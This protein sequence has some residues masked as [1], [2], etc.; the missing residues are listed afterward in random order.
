MFTKRAFANKRSVDNGGGSKKY[1]LP[2]TVGVPAMLHRFINIRAGNKRGE[3]NK[4]W[5]FINDLKSPDGDSGDP[6]YFGASVAIYG[7]Y[8]VVGATYQDVSDNDI[9]YGKAYVFEISGNTI[10]E[11]PIASL[12]SPDVD[13]NNPPLFGSSVAIYGKYIVVG[14]PLQDVSGNDDYGKA[15]VFEISG[16]TISDTPIAS[17]K[18]PD[19]DNGFSNFPQFGRSVAI[20]DKYIVVG[21][22]GQDVSDNAIDYGKAYVFEISGNT[23]SETPIASLKSP[24][25]DINNPPLFGS[26]VAIYGKYIVVGAPGQDVPPDSDDF[27]K[28]Y[29]FKINSNNTIIETPIASLESP[30]VDGSDKFGQSVAIYGKYIVV[31]APYNGNDLLTDY[32]DIYVFK[33]NGNDTISETPIASFKSPDG[34]GGGSILEAEFGSSVAIYDDYIV[35][36]APYQDVPPDSGDYGK[37]YVFKNK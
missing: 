19:V 36:G 13:I 8:I 20:Y 28:A 1:G 9:D 31:G 6:P 16:N 18:S 33:I 35:V 32:G 23:I 14:A 17:L 29:V 21:A 22:P 27:G 10:D 2:G 5:T 26:S 3:P 11:T 24:D 30:G 15:Y 34:D 4:I 37:A 25:V 12:K 7:K